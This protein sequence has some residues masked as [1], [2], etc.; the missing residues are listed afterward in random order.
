MRPDGLVEVRV[1]DSPGGLPVVY[2]LDPVA[3][4]RLVTYWAEVA[5]AQRTHRAACRDGF[6]RDEPATTL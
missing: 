5:E 1:E 6:S 3:T 2:V 4:P